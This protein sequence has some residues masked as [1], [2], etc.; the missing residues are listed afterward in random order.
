MN[1]STLDRIG[2]ETF[3]ISDLHLGH[4]NITQFEPCRLTAMRI[5]GHDNHE[6][7]VI[8]NWNEQVKEDE[9]VFILGDFSFK[10][11]ANYISKL[12]GNLIFI[13]GNHDSAPAG[14]KWKGAEIV[15]GIWI[16]ING[17]CTRIYDDFMFEDRLMSG[18]IKD[19]D[20]ER[21]LF[22]HYDIFSEDDW[23]RKNKKIGPRIEYFRKLY[24]DFNCTRLVHGH[25]HSLK[26]T[27]KDKSI[28]VCMEQEHMNFRPQRFGNL[29][30]N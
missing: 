29:I 27:Q 5:D 4:K 23:D 19:I 15:R 13:L 6:D 30:N 17:Y 16:D 14:E 8:E 7:W 20:G 21:Y 11:V 3:I 18:L 22:C 9:D 10:S 1:K 28:N 24:E 12:N 25:V 2:K 26:S